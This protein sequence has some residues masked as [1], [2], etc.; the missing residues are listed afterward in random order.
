MDYKK[1]AKKICKILEND[2]GFF[3]SIEEVVAWL[4]TIDED[5]VVANSP[6]ELAQWFVQDM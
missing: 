3:L 5:D 1:I 4:E 6:E 2:E